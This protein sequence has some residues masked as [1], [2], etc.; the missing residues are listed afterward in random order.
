L[1]TQELPHMEYPYLLLDAGGTLVFPDQELIAR[2]LAAR[3]CAL[4]PER[5]YEAHFRLVHQ[6]DVQFRGGTAALSI[7]IGTF[8]RDMMMH[9]GA[10][11]AD[12]EGVV[13]GLV[14]RHDEI[15]LWTYTKP[16]V[17][18]TLAL[19]QSRGVRMS[20]ISNSDGRVRQQLEACGIIPYLETV[21]DSHVVGIEKPD[22]GIFLHALGQLGLA[23]ADCLYVGDFYHADVVGANRAGIASV[24]LDPLDCYGDWAG[25]HLRDIRALPACLAELRADPARFDLFPARGCPRGGS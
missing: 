16:W 10:P 17:A 19:L 4:D 13:D 21:F 20:V 14:A 23:A 5:I 3:G 8:Y 9:A 12:A 1:L 15:S 18:E 2:T 7:S 22:P 11:R 6:Y 24:H 25:V